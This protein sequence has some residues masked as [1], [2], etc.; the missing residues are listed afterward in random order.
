LD[1]DDVI[2][3]SL[4]AFGSKP[5]TWGS[6]APSFFSRILVRNSGALP[7][8]VLTL[9]QAHPFQAALINELFW[10]YQLEQQSANMSSSVPILPLQ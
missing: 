10:Q 3:C 6:A 2:P 4:P 1:Q 7:S 5:S 8:N 9:T